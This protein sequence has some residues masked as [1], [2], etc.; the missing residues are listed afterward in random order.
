[1]RVVARR[2]PSR[3]SDGRARRAR[4]SG[5]AA[6]SRASPRRGAARAAARVSARVAQHR[7]FGDRVSSSPL[8]RGRRLLVGEA[9]AAADHRAVEAR[10]AALAALVERDLHRQREPIDVRAQRAEVARQPLG[11]HRDRAIREVHAVAA[12]QRLAIDRRARPA[13]TRHVRDRHPEPRSRRARSR[14]HT[15]SS[16]SRAVAGSIVTKGARAGRAARRCRP[17]APRLGLARALGGKLRGSPWRRTPRRS[18]RPGRPRRPRLRPARTR[19]RASKRTATISPGLSPS[20]SRSGARNEPSSGC[21]R[22]SSPRRLAHTTARC[23]PLCRGA[24]R[25]IA[26]A[27]RF[28][29][30]PAASSPR[31]R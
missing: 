1:M 11:Q 2:G 10:A 27:A 6:R 4:T 7:R 19:P 15:A 30:G 31:L 5:S 13:P 14:R 8:D 22:S 3:R 24:A 29:A 21:G 25:G 26:V 28:A 20:A 16:W 12:P 17:R 18:R 23:A 9:R